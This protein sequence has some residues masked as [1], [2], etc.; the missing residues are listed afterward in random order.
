L[1]FR[2]FTLPLLWTY[3]GL[4]FLSLLLALLGQTIPAILTPLSTAACFAFVVLHTEQRSGWKRALLFLVIS[5]S[6]SLVLESFGVATGYVYGPYHYTDS[7][8]P[9]FLGLVPW[10]IP[11][12]WFMMLVPSLAIADLL[13]PQQWK[14]AWV[15]RLALPALGAVIMT[16]W[17]LAL[18]PLM[19]AS[20]HWVWE[21]KGVYFGIP[22]QNYW[23]WWLTSFLIFWLYLQL[24]AEN[25]TLGPGPF[26]SDGYLV[27][28]YLLTAGGSV[29]INSIYHQGGPALVG[30]FA[31]FPWVAAGY[32]KVVERMDSNVGES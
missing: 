6:V 24:G 15:R 16:A 14:M 20:N 21:V 2:R 3:A 30:L 29:V 19:V 4:V 12:A 8:G 23:G 26:I 25:K 18:D 27:T 31:I 13:L 1:F 9:K 11:L 22:L 10:L 28:A 17:D 32:F 5:F 7:L